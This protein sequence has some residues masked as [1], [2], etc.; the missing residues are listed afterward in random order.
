VAW[1]RVAAGQRDANR[2]TAANRSG[3]GDPLGRQFRAGR[4]PPDFR[5]TRT[6]QGQSPVAR[7]QLTPVNDHLTTLPTH[8][9]GHYL[10]TGLMECLAGDDGSGCVPVQVPNDRHDMTCT[11]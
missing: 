2:A 10:G 1:Q 5:L 4:S 8:C 7:S 11:P 9:P 6:W 3:V